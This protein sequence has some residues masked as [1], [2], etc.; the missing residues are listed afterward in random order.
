M[1]NI[2]TSIVSSPVT[3]TVI[4]LLLRMVNDL[5]M[6]G[7]FTRPTIQSFDNFGP[8]ETHI[9]YALVHEPCYLSG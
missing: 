2:Y 3:E 7:F 5:S 9:L 6:F 1:V 8:F 4:G